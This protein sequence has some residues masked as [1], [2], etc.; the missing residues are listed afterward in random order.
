MA[1]IVL[2]TE[3]NIIIIET[4]GAQGPE[5][6]PGASSTH[7]MIDHLAEPDP[8]PQ[9]LLKSASTFVHI[10]ST[11]LDTWI[12]THNMAKFPAVQVVDSAGTEVIGNLT[13]TSINECVLTFNGAFSGSAICN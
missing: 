8:H 9:Y 6:I 3:S 4:P 11:P 1:D 2:E 10:Q 13:H 12:V 7:Q 5:G